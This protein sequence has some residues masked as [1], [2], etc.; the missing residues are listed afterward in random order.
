MGPSEL[1]QCCCHRRC[2]AR[3]LSPFHSSRGSYL[4]EIMGLLIAEREQFYWEQQSRTRGRLG[5]ESTPTLLADSVLAIPPIPPHPKPTLFFP[6]RFF[7]LFV[8]SYLSFFLPDRTSSFTVALFLP[9]FAKTS[10]FLS[11]VFFFTL[12]SHYD[13]FE[14]GDI[15]CVCLISLSVA[16]TSPSFSSLVFISPLLLETLKL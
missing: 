5:E 3:D 9:S 10:P 12:K 6:H 7:F 2:C 8:S 1:R 4:G 11:F 16:L 13:S 15:S 14:P